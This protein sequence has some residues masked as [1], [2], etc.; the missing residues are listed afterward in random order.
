MQMLENNWVQARNAFIFLQGTVSI[1]LGGLISTQLFD[2]GDSSVVAAVHPCVTALDII[3][4]KW[5]CVSND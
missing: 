1:S 5:R 4:Y 3:R 2:N